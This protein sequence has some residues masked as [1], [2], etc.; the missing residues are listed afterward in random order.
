MKSNSI[1]IE[2]IQGS[3]QKGSTII[4]SR[5]RCRFQRK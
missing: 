5:N 2:V 4:S 1:L 3:D